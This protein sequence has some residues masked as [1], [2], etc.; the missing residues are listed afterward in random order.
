MKIRWK[1]EIHRKKKKHTV[2]YE[3]KENDI[4]PLN[5]AE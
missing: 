2:E 4:L 5:V 1:R 3:K